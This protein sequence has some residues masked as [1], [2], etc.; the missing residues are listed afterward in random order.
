[1]SI[2]YA[3]NV[4]LVKTPPQVK[5]GN[6][7]Y[8]TVQIGNLIWTAE[9]LE[10]P[11]GVNGRNYKVINGIYYYGQH[12]DASDKINQLIAGSGFRLPTTADSLALLQNNTLA[13]LCA[14]TGWDNLGTNTTTMNLPQANVPLLGN[15]DRIQ[16]YG[17]VFCPDLRVQNHFVGIELENGVMSLFEGGGWASNPGLPCR[18]C[19]DV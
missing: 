10:E 4:G 15:G 7:L 9:C 18:L 17:F 11:L 16:M 5:I 19:R 12:S 14:T 8:R 13:S 2:S 3:K 1:M 6:K